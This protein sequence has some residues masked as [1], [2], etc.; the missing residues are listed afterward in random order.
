[1][2]LPHAY[3][4]PVQ[5]SPPSWAAQAIQM[6]LLVGVKP[7]NNMNAKITSQITCDLHHTPAHRVAA[8]KSPSYRHKIST[9]TCT[10]THIHFYPH[11]QVD[12]SS[13]TQKLVNLPCRTCWQCDC[14][15]LQ[16][17]TNNSQ[18]N[19]RQTLVIT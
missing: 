4:Q 14:Q 3:C 12:T 9:C 19:S 6:W 10:L 16:A 13:F 17:H 18:Q 15:N 1:M 2:V 7:N 5:I 8:T 11:S